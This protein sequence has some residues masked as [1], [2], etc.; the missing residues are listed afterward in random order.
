MID[1]ACLEVEGTLGAF[2][3]LLD[4][5]R[6]VREAVRRFFI[7][8][9]DDFAREIIAGIIE[10]F[11]RGNRNGVPALHVKD[12]RPIGFAVFDREGTL[13]YF[14]FVENGVHVSHQNNIRLRE[15]SPFTNDGVPTFFK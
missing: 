5:V 3:F 4:H 13:L 8:Y 6:I 11:Q 1:E 12:A 2:G 15:V 10:S 7:G 14:P 9:E